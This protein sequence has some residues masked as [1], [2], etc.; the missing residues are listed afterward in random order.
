M[1]G[2]GERK[3]GEGD[4]RRERDKRGEGGGM[5]ER[6]GEWGAETR[7]GRGGG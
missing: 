4:E 3:L 5:R 7:R 6:S 2:K 1:K